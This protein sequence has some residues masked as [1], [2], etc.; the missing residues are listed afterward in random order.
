MLI[1]A[2]PGEQ[3]AVVVQ[4]RSFSSAT[5]RVQAIVYRGISEDRR[6]DTIGRNAL[7]GQPMC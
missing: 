7:T 3:S 5:G 6:I 4:V 1:H 2:F